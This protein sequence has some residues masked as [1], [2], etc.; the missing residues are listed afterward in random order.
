M[1]ALSY[2]IDA[3][4]RIG[5]PTE[6]SALRRQD[7]Q[8]KGQTVL[9]RNQRVARLGDEVAT[10]FHAVV[11]P[12]PEVVTHL[13]DHEL[14]QIRRNSELAESMFEAYGVAP[15]ADPLDKLDKSFEL[16]LGDNRDWP[17]SEVVDLLGAH[18]GEYCSAQLGM[19]WVRVKDSYGIALA[20][21]GIDACFRA[22][23]YTSVEKRIA[24]GEHTFFRGIFIHLADLKQRSR[25][26]DDALQPCV[27]A[28]RGDRP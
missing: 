1:S 2:I 14:A 26:R 10:G 6:R 11:E 12:Y 23:P 4:R 19:R 16:W 17:Q 15:H 25:P 24:D 21:D 28:D 27:H 8:L 13:Q 22:F 3:L 18:F 7:E 5:S 20:I 9:E